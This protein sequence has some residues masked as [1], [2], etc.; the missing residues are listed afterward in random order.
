ME[1]T[2][3]IILSI[4]YNKEKKTKRTSSF[5]NFIRNNKFILSVVSITIVFMA[6]DIILVNNFIKLLSEI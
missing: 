6:C 2:K 1:Y 3:D 4:N 5:I